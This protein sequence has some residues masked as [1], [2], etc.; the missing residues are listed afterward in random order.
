[1][2]SEEVARGGAVSSSLVS[3]A[4]TNTHPTVPP[5]QPR[6]FMHSSSADVFAAAA[7]GGG[8]LTTCP[9]IDTGGGAA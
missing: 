4:H 2:I 6:H 7:R 1:M 8:L 3:S 5:K 9:I